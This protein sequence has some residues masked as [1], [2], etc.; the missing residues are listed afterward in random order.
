MR[1]ALLDLISDLPRDASGP[2]F[3]EP[4]EAEAFALTL[5]LYDKGVFSWTEW[6]EALSQ[7]IKAA[8]AGDYYDHWLHALEHLVVRKQVTTQDRLYEVR[9][10]WERAAHAT[11]HGEP[12]DP[13]SNP[14]ARRG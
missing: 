5:A 8:G 3:H 9:D 6:T 13:A 11:P 12:I 4:W 7:E 14:A 2:V 1:E 10:A